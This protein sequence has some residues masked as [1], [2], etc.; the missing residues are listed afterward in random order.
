M[1]TVF[2]SFLKFISLS[3]GRICSQM[4]VQDAGTVG[5]PKQLVIQKDPSSI[6]DAVRKA[7]LALPLGML[8]TY[9]FAY[10]SSFL[11]SPSGILSNFYTC[12]SC[13]AVGCKVS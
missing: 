8:Q 5:V 2:F 7:G 1:H 6:S 3:D 9:G 11:I 12:H 4:L 10:L 13:K